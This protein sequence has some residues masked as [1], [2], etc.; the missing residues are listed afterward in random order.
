MVILCL[1][2]T[3]TLFL[4]QHA[5]PAGCLVSSICVNSSFHFYLA[6][7]ELTH[8]RC[9]VRQNSST[10]YVVL[11]DLTGSYL[12]PPFFA[13]G[14]GGTCSAYGMHIITLESTTK[15]SEFWVHRCNIVVIIQSHCNYKY[16][17]RALGNFQL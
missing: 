11:I 9:N 5:G 1:L 17:R 14:V 2:L 15:G 12:C 6:V 7:D 13:A 10:Y 4:L 8:V 3:K 16:C